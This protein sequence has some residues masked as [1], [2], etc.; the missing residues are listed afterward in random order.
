M[1]P[2]AETDPKTQMWMYRAMLLDLR[3]DECA[4]VLQRQGKVTFHVSCIGHD[5]LADLDAPVQRLASRLGAHVR[6]IYAD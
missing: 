2:E 6:E 4:W 1:T 5:A 3:L